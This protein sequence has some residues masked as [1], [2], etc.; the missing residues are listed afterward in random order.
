MAL[1]SSNHHF[2]VT[3]SNHIQKKKERS[4]LVV[5]PVMAVV[6]GKGKKTTIP[7]YPDHIHALRAGLEKAKIKSEIRG[8]KGEAKE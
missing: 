2:K 5:N 1:F 3:L 7:R 6:L 4:L 8:F